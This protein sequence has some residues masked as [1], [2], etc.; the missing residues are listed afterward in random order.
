MKIRNYRLCLNRYFRM[1][2]FRRFAVLQSVKLLSLPSSSDFLS[3]YQ[4]YNA[5]RCHLCSCGPCPS[6]WC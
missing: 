2:W 6:Q 5:L 3:R 1:R 4:K